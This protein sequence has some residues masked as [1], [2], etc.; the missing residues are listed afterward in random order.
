[1][2][3]VISAAFEFRLGLAT[4]A[5]AAPGTDQVGTKQGLSGDQVK[6]IS[7]CLQKKSL[8][9][10]MA[11]INRK[12]RTKF[13]DQVLNPMIDL[14]LIEMTI[15]DKP[16]SSKQKYKLTDKSRQAVKSLNS[17]EQQ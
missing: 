11:V 3:V 2:S 13:R 14:G 10:M 16:C 4:V 9:E 6:V 7:N 8:V 17:N 1:M 15:P 12:N 5:A